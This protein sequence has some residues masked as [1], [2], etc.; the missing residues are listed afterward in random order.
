MRSLT[1]SARKSNSKVTCLEL[2]QGLMRLRGN[3]F[4]DVSRAMQ[5][6]GRKC[7]HRSIRALDEADVDLKSAMSEAGKKTRAEK[8]GTSGRNV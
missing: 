1:S 3:R 5:C 7:A 8:I 6:T 4:D 2:Q